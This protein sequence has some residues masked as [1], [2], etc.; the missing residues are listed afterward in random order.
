MARLEQT[1]RIAHRRAK[2][3]CIVLPL[4]G[5]AGPPDSNRLVPDRSGADAHAW[6]TI[7][8][9]YRPT[10]NERLA[11]TALLRCEIAGRAEP[12][13]AGHQIAWASSL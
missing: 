8:M 3:R 10:R 1:A 6:R 11:Q 7:P 12:G 4:S 13:R 5:R 2:V 9:C